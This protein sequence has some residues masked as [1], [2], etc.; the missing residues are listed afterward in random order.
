MDRILFDVST[1]N[2]TSQLP[3]IT[4]PVIMDSNL[5]GA[6]VDLSRPRKRDRA[7]IRQR[8]QWLGSTQ[9]DHRRLRNGIST[10]VMSSMTIART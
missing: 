1:V 10:G 3:T 4:V 9:H 8:R 5:G 2:I 6:R 7:R